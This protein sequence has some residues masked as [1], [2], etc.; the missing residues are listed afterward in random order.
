M[1]YESYKRGG[2]ET[3]EG[4]TRHQRDRMSFHSICRICN[5]NHATLI[6]ILAITKIC[7]TWRSVGCGSTGRERYKKNRHIYFTVTCI[8]VLSD[9]S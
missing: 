6:W 9:D 7:L 3:E 4:T 1:D 5:G 2:L 8:D